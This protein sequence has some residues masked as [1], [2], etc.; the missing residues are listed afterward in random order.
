MKDSREKTLQLID[1]YLAGEATEAQRN[2]LERLYAA[3]TLKKE[4]IENLDQD[5]KDIDRIGIESWMQIISEIRTGKQ[6]DDY[7]EPN[8]L[9]LKQEVFN[10][11]RF[12]QQQTGTNIRLWPRIAIVATVSVIMFG[13]G[14]FYFTRQDKMGEQFQDG[15]TL[16]DIAPGKRGAT[17][18]LANGKKIRLSAATNGKIAEE[19]GITVTKTEDGQLVYEITP[20]EDNNTTSISYNTLTTA[21]GE[22]YQV[23]LPDG[24]L[25]FLNAASSLKYPTRFAIHQTRRVSLTGEGYF[26]IAKVTPRS[27]VGSNLSV[28]DRKQFPEPVPFIVTTDK[29][30]VH[31]LGTHFNV[32]AYADENQTVTTLLEGSVKVLQLKNNLMTP[33]MSATGEVAMLIPGQ[34]ALNFDSKI[35]VSNAD[36]KT[37]TAWKNGHLAFKKASIKAVLRQISRWYDLEVQYEGKTPDYTIT[38]EVSRAE[39]L[40]V[41]LKILEQSDVHFTLKGRKLIIKS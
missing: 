26:E 28:S 12:P 14:L 10:A 41:I 23:R 30:E 32:N 17:L 5:V 29:Q 18:T 3:A 6:K 7:P 39:N 8:Y 27:L 9:G 36:I 16:N 4:F 15:L 38:G 1:I 31:V 25:V 11:I 37:A 19:G 20:P 2:K 13:V 24:S 34:Q 21:K 33:S 35:S 22:A 40:S